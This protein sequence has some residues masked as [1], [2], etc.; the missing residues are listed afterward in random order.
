MHGAKSRLIVPF[1]LAFSRLVFGSDAILNEY[2]A[3]DPDEFLN[4]GDASAD[5]DGGRA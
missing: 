5:L 3:V 2:N 4:G 1:I